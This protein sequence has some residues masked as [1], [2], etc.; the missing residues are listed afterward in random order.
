MSTSMFNRRRASNCIDKNPATTTTIKHRITLATIED[1]DLLDPICDSVS[2]EPSLA[3]SSV[4]NVSTSTPNGYESYDMSNTYTTSRQPL[5]ADNPLISNSSLLDMTRGSDDSHDDD[6][7]VSVDAVN[8]DAS[9]RSPDTSLLDDDDDDDH[10]HEEEGDAVT[11]MERSI[12]NLS[13]SLSGSFCT[14]GDEV[15]FMDCRNLSDR[16]SQKVHFSDKIIQDR[17]MKDLNYLL[18]STT[19][20]CCMEKGLFSDCFGSG[21]TTTTLETTLTS[22]EAKIRNR[23]GESWRAR[24]Y[25]IKRLRE[26]KMIQDSSWRS[27]IMKSGNISSGMD[28]GISWEDNAMARSTSFGHKPFSVPNST[29]AMKPMQEFNVEPLGCMI[30]DCIE[31]I[32]SLESND[33][34]VDRQEY[35]D[36]QD[37]CYDSDPGISS[38]HVEQQKPDL[39]SKENFDFQ[40]HERSKSETFSSNVQSSPRKKWFRSPRRR[41]RKMHFDSFDDLPEDGKVHNERDEALD[42]IRADFYGNGC[43]ES[44]ESESFDE[45]HIPIPLSKRANNNFID[46]E[47]Q[48]HVQVR[49]LERLCFISMIILPSISFQLTSILPGCLE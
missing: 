28:D 11:V 8:K 23:A 35:I 46:K 42:L 2:T 32:S 49:I 43:E 13:A 26:E 18:G 19:N 37:L 20:P 38:N 47:I 30:G 27:T 29:N 15:G 31:P 12:A 4:S 1:E 39:Q 9:Y 3:N 45:P 34:E 44:A 5:H 25:R 16:I 7:N 22:V 14:R 17:V 36:E 48:F 6:N 21:K 33:V 24:A 41:R 40:M 10:E